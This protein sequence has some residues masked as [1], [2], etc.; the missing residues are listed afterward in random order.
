M[1]TSAQR[2]I[3]VLALLTVLL[4]SVGVLAQ[5]VEGRVVA[6]RLNIRSAPAVDDANIIG[7]LP[8]NALVSIEGRTADNVWLYVR[9]QDGSV[10]GWG[11]AQFVAFDAGLLASI[12][13]SDTS[14]PAAPQTPAADAPVG[15]AAAEGITTTIINVRAQ[16]LI[17]ASNVLTQLAAQTPVVIEARNVVGDWLLVRMGDGSVR[18]WVAANYVRLSGVTVEALPVSNDGVTAA[19]E[20]G[21][22]FSST[23]PTASLDLIMET[24]ILHN[25]TTPTVY[26]TFQKGQRLGNNPRVFMKV[27]DS[28][29]AT[30]PF[31]TGFGSGNYSLGP[32]GDLQATIEFFSVSPVNNVPN[33]FVQTSVAAVNGFVSGAVFD[34]TWSPE[35]CGKLVPLHCE[36]DILRPSVAI[37]LFGG[38]DLRLF[39]AALFQA[40]LRKIAVDL[41]SLGVIPIFTTFPMHPDYRLQETIQ[42]NTVVINVAN[43]HNIPL[44]NLYR[45]LQSLPNG[46]A[47]PEDPV[48]LTQGDNA[49][50]FNG[51]EALYGVNVRNLLTLQ[52]LDILRRNVLQ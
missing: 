47:K 19:A 4:S 25:M 16:P 42:F 28:V 21:T 14:A 33:S 39:D 37:V 12:P 35:Y 5:G 31:M 22:P 46:G 49:Y 11:A 26:A 38:Q 13:I 43:E 45:A 48:H 3:L 50:S 41:K 20:S 24:P 17:T 1:K 8:V 10:V 52:A 7:E 32:Y 23:I 51:E 44:I 2:L 27:G 6:W 9:A 40:N 30:Q 34:G 36:Y 15:A 18:G 29:T